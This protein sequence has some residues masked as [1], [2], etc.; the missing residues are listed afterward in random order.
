MNNKFIW[1]ATAFA[2]CYITN[3]VGEVIVLVA[4]AIL[5]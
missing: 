2:L 1:A 3:T 5:G 4:M